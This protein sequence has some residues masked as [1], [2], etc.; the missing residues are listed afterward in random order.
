[1]LRAKRIATDVPEAIK[2]Q[3]SDKFCPHP[4][5]TFDFTE[6]RVIGCNGEPPCKLTK[7][8]N[9]MLYRLVKRR[10]DGTPGGWCTWDELEKCTPS[11]NMR[12]DED[13]THKA[14]KIR[15]TRDERIDHVQKAI[16]S[17]RKT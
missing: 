6:R 7:M 14:I 8:Q 15:R 13:E 12:W 3:H 11:K 4:G 9:K 17:L 5:L 2:G 16:Y 10:I 1:M